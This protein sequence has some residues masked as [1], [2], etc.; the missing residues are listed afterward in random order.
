MKGNQWPLVVF[1]VL[2]QLAV[3]LYLVSGLLQFALTGQPGRIPTSFYLRSAVL[4]VIAI[5]VVSML[6]SLFH[7]G[8]PKNSV[9]TILNLGSSWLSAEIAMVLLFL[10]AGAGYLVVLW[11]EMS[12]L[13]KVGFWVGS[14][15]GL[16]LVYCMTKVYRLPTVPV[17]DSPATPVSFYRT[18]LLLGV[19]TAG[20]LLLISRLL[21][22][23]K[24]ALIVELQHLKTILLW[25]IVVAL[26]LVGFDYSMIIFREVIKTRDPKRLE[27]GSTRA[28]TPYGPGKSLRI[29]FSL[30]GL[31]SFGF[32]VFWAYYLP[33][34]RWLAI[35]LMGVAFVSI[36]ISELIDRRLFYASYV[37]PGF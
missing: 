14:G 33:P 2:V 7:L 30:A 18:S 31:I 5:L 27:N 36:L 13:G 25:M 21:A 11:L 35:L 17:W 22:T 28:F 4:T 29:V 15:I 19:V 26:F 20:G 34:N 37:R 32:S 6:I 9:R 10:F 3:G 8:S 1:T 12:T 23:E 24:M 16:A